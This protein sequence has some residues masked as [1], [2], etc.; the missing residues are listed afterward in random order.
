MNILI[1]NIVFYIQKRGGI[2]VVWN[3]II[4]RILKEKNV[5]VKFLD[6][7]YS[8]N[9]FRKR[10]NINKLSLIKKDNRFLSFKRYLNPS[11]EMDG[12]FIF[13]STYYRTCNRKNAINF[14]TVH[15]FT[16]EKFYPFFK[17]IIHS[18]QKNKAIRKADYV[19]C[20]SENTKRDCLKYVKNIDSEKVKVIYNGVSDCYF[21]IENKNS[22]DLPFPANSYVLFVGDRSFYKNFKLVVDYWKNS[23]YNLVVVG[24]NFNEKEKEFFDGTCKK[25]V[26]L[27]DISNEK[28]N[29]IYNGAF[30]LIYPSSYEGFGIPVLEA[31]KASCP[32]IAYNA[33]SIP[34]V[35]GYKYFLLNNL[36]V[37]E[38]QEKTQFLENESNRKSIIKSGIEFAKRFTWDNTY[39]QLIELYKKAYGDSETTH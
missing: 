31:Q 14:T 6:Y 1:D 38:I 3:E 22:L 21:P 39:N 5:T 9:I 28:L 11:C 27:T 35:I 2:S 34:E 16:Y 36:S 26:L 8:D 20:V 7:G 18:Y 33:S 15:D 12:K 29:E 37:K 23:E 32:V 4:S 13:H 24:S 10:L 30:C 19:V 17:R 25:H